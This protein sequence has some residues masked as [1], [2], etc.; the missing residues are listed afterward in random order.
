M[1]MDRA[2]KKKKHKKR[3]KDKL[4][5]PYVFTRKDNEM[6]KVC[7]S[8]YV[9]LRKKILKMM[10]A[11]PRTNQPTPTPA[12]P[13]ANE[14]DKIQSGIKVIKR[15]FV[16]SNKTEVCK[17]KGLTPRRASEIRQHRS[18]KKKEHPDSQMV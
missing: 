2:R 7:L 6:R 18:K 15:S 5:S 10:C 4:R 12:N 1:H 11:C 8:K 14:I 9:Q 16:K 13:K 17:T 3:K